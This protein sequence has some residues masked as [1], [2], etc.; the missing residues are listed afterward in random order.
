MWPQVYDPLGNAA[1]STIAAAVPIVVLLGTL[2]IL[3]VKAHHAALYGLTASLIVA[4]LVF[5]MPAPMAG[6]SAVFGA[7]Y[8]LFPIG[9]IV[10]H[11]IFL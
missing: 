1:I 8:G 6:A 5:G 2:G 7:A 11:V 3:R 9:W 10:V 4:V